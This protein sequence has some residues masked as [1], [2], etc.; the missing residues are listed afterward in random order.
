MRSRSAFTALSRSAADMAMP[1]ARAASAAFATSLSVKVLEP[2]PSSRPGAAARAA[3]MLCFSM[4]F[5]FMDVE[6]RLCRP[7][8][9]LNEGLECYRGMV[10][11]IGEPGTYRVGAAKISRLRGK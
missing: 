10:H 4:G 9:G 7:V 8:D 11:L 3:L 5:S 1:S 6:G 2:A